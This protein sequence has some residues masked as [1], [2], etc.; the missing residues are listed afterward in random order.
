MTDTQT[1][2]DALTSPEE[3]PAPRPDGQI[4]I[5]QTKV[6]RGPNV[7]ARVPVIHLIVDIGELE[8]RPSNV[9]PGFVDRLV[10]QIPTL[11][12][13]ECSLGH[14]GGF[15]E[16]LHSGTWMGHILEHV[17]LEIQGLAGI[18]VTR[19]KT[20]RTDERGVYNVIYAYKQEDVGL[21]A[22]R[23]ATRFLNHLVYGTE[24]GFD[25][26]HELEEE[27]IRLADQVA[28]GPS[29]REI[30]EEA[31]RRGIPVMRLSPNHSL[32]QLGQG[33]YQ[34]RIWATRTSS[35]SGVAMD[36]AGNKELTN[37][38][39]RDAGIPS[40]RG[41]AVRNQKEAVRAAERIGYPVVLKPLDGNHGRGVCLNLLNAAEVRDQFKVAKAASRSG[42]VVV[43]RMLQGKDYRV[44]VVN[45]E[46]V[47]VA[48][49][50]P[51]HVVG[52][53]QHSVR[54]LIEMTNADPRRGIGHEKILTRISIDQQTEE[55]LAGQGLSLED[56]PENGQHVRL[57]MTGNMSTGG[58]SIDR[59]D[60]IH[61]DNVEIALEA[62]MIVGLDVAGIDFVS[63]DISRSVH[64][65]GGGIVEINAA[66][67]FRM[68]T[69]PTEGLPRQVGHAVVDML[70]PQDAPSSVPIIA[71]TGTNGKTTTT[72][73][74]AHIM[75][76]DGQTVGMTTSDGIY[77][78]GTQIAAGDMAGPDSARMVLR[79]PRVEV[80]V[81]ETAR[82]GIL[83][84]GLGFDRCN[85][86][87]VTNVASDH[88]GM[89]GVNTIDDLAQVKQVVPASV[90]R[91]G[92]SV[93][94]ADNPW[95][96]AMAK[97]AR[98][99]IIYFSM[100]EHN[101]LI[102]RHIR[103]QGRA[104][105]LRETAR[106]GMLTLV[107]PRRETNILL[108]RDIPA[109]FNERVRVN[110][111]NALAASAA[112][113]GADV[114]LS[115]I[116]DSLRTFSTAYWQTPGRFNL[117]M[118][119]GKQVVVD[120][121]H[122]V[123]GLQG[124]ADFVRRTPVPQSIG[125]I[126]I[127]GDRRDDDI[128]E[129]G[130]LAGRTFDR[131]VIREHDDR[132]GRPVGEVAELLRQAVLS[133]GKAPDKIDVVLDELDAVNAAIDLASPGDLVV[134]MVYRIQRVWDALL[135]RQERSQRA[136]AARGSWPVPPGMEAAM[137]AMPGD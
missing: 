83:R 58:T 19:G 115:C 137:P 30:V 119:E 104:V 55:T 62:A 7:W 120:Y 34:R 5:R 85:V 61:P 100:D 117:I 9:I 131:V 97:Y 22:G 2:D 72:R 11:E 15:I 118:I 67:G 36:I 10:E 21:A 24:P 81:L 8:E 14:R 52:D 27:V 86:A 20:R 13:H 88:L 134:S 37:Q 114:P 51:A 132:R 25:F 63:P 4:T 73:M 87:V 74:I 46:V 57:K 122:N 98:G 135:E 40:P 76:K 110:V 136:G 79:N 66:P 124:I 123:D 45:N 68:H 49:R 41:S 128:R 108:A 103:R 60:E 121:C 125:V 18:H 105:I 75:Q 82:G 33:K 112:A 43:E 54:D 111:A 53:G 99:E 113:I 84:A 1:S 23:L 6:L 126:A 93:L 129:F 90:L 17:A 95:T 3:P 130:E 102:A 116:R 91:D 48:E 47:A 78:N 65:S 94:N 127:A 96:V 64:E 31:E 12:E 38:L 29:T 89:T 32:V 71:V 39:L 77:V 101:P 80:A 133:T 109:T 92:A 69:H 107:E 16:R 42:S 28:F 44:V 56:I 70:F 35:T 106:G 26:V 50:V 59:T